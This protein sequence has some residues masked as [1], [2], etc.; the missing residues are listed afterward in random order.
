[1]I[2]IV[3]YEFKNRYQSFVN[4]NSNLFFIEGNGQFHR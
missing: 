4:W 3:T 1:M 2:S